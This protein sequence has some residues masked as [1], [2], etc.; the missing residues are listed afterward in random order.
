M[1]EDREATSLIG[2]QQCTHRGD[3]CQID[4]GKPDD[5]DA[6]RA[7]PRHRIRAGAMGLRNS[8]ITGVALDDLPDGG[9]WL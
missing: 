9:A 6:G 4:T 2:G 8:T 5:L 3:F 7:P 1:L